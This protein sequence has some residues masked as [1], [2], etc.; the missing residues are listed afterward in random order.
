MSHRSV[1]CDTTNTIHS[2][3]NTTKL[4]AS[5]IQSIQ[6]PD[7]N[8]LMNSSVL[9]SPNQLP[10][11][12][13]L[14]LS[15]SDDDDNNESTTNENNMNL[16]H[17]N[18]NGDA[19]N[20]RQSLALTQELA[21]AL[22]QQ[23]SDVNTAP[24]NDDSHHD[25]DTTYSELYGNEF[26]TG[27]IESFLYEPIDSNNKSFLLDN[28]FKPSEHQYKQYMRLIESQ[29]ESTNF[30]VNLNEMTIRAMIERDNAIATI[31]E[32][33]SKQIQYKQILSKI[34][35]MYEVKSNR[36]THE[37]SQNDTLVNENQL[38]YSENNKLC[39]DINNVNTT[40]CRLENE[41]N[42]VCTNYQELLPTYESECTLRK[43]LRL[44]NKQLTAENKQLKLQLDQLHDTSNNS[45]LHDELT[46][47]LQQRDSTIIQL[48]QT[49]DNMIQ[50]NLNNT[51]RLSLCTNDIDNNT[52]DDSTQQLIQSL[53]S[54]LTHM[55]SVIEISHT[56]QLH[57]QNELKRVQADYTELIDRYQQIETTNHKLKDEIEYV[58]SHHVS[59][60]Q[61]EQY[62][63]QYY[64]AV[65]RYNTLQQQYH[66]IEQLVTQMNDVSNKQTDIEHE[67]TQH[68]EHIGVKYSELRAKLQLLQCDYVELQ[69]QYDSKCTELAD[70]ISAIELIQ[71]E[72]S[73]VK[74]QYNMVDE[75]CVHLYIANM[76]DTI[77]SNVV[78]QCLSNDQSITV[79]Q[80]CSVTQ[81]YNELHTRYDVI[82][83]RYNTMDAKY[84][85]QLHDI[86][87]LTTQIHQLIN[88]KATLIES[89][90]LQSYE[91]QELQAQYDNEQSTVNAQNAV[92]QQQIDELNH[93]NHTLTTQLH[94]S[95]TRI[96]ALC[97][98]N[99]ILIQQ[100]NDTTEQITQLQSTI[101]HSQDELHRSQQSVDELTMKLQSA[102]SILNSTK[103]EYNKLNELTNELQRITKSA[104][105]DVELHK[106]TII[107]LDNQIKH[108]TND[109][110]QL[111]CDLNDNKQQHQ[112]LSN[113]YTG[114]KSELKQC[115]IE[116]QLSNEQCIALRQQ[117]Q[118]TQSTSTVQSTNSVRYSSMERELDE[119]QSLYVLSQGKI[120]Q[121]EVSL[122]NKSDQCDSMSMIL[123]NRCIDCDSI[124][125]LSTATGTT[126]PC[127]IKWAF[128]QLTQLTNELQSCK[129]LLHDTISERDQIIAHVDTLTQTTKNITNNQNDIAEL[130][131]RCDQLSSQNS[132]LQVKCMAF[133]DNQLLLTEKSEMLNYT[134]DALRKSCTLVQRCKLSM[135]RY[136]ADYNDEINQSDLEQCMS[137]MGRYYEKNQILL[138][139]FVG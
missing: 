110:H 50:S 123:S 69:L 121:L 85:V 57:A 74:Q 87:V 16:S 134:L 81:Q 35:S 48:Q 21:S 132:Q 73:Q 86:D 105:G 125:P 20:N 127:S 32:L 64:D 52:V 133:D 28:T 101:Q 82:T 72:S 38:L 51:K 122:K 106:Q 62:K 23:L 83:D 7:N 77:V 112:E 100:F 129:Q 49:I 17:D 137:D 63:A 130:I 139:S 45:Q 15:S 131:K 104:N 120:A 42:T 76:I 59:H 26:G 67:L 94:D 109:Y 24:N 116:L 58:T 19:N 54:E 34:H 29:L 102:E 96:D 97:S 93:T 43:Q 8:K 115:K 47:Q 128:T 119:L 89:I 98:H 75:Q 107:Q 2:P 117:L 71:Y 126:Q 6:S 5:I 138:N 46:Q 135:S 124:H 44:N 36:L 90:E 80:L 65:Q 12:D 4:N 60:Q 118:R 13:L 66:T 33:T 10:I 53:E 1:L 70:S 99:T 9:N 18:D 78:V 37:L 111:Q 108:H 136:R 103:I 11:D 30:T 40:L 27:I 95:T 79:H 3:M 88:D 55:A 84:T 39:D 113:K 25:T 56:A 14:Q 114:V 31:D 68:T 91:Q 61:N 41:Y 22:F 92:Y